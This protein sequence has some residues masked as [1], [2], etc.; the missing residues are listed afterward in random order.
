MSNPEGSA[1]AADSSAAVIAAYNSK[2]KKAVSTIVLTISPS[3]LYL[4]GDPVD[5]SVVWGKLENHFQKPCWVS[6][7]EVVYH[8][9]TTIQHEDEF[10][11]Y[12]Q[13]PCQEN[14]GIV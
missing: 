7:S 5:P 8:T 12:H 2:K 13:R 9:K 6:G 3:L 11:G 10:F 1:P 14:G 4:I